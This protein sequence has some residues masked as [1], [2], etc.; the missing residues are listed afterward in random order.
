MTATSRGLSGAGGRIVV[1]VERRPARVAS[2]LAVA[3]VPLAA[4]AMFTGTY[5]LTAQDLLDVV[6]GTAGAPVERVVLL[7]RMPRL[8]AALAVGAALGLSGA[9][10]QSLSRNPLGS[11]DVIGFVTGAAT[12]AITAILLFRAPPAVVSLSAVAGGVLTALLV[13]LLARRPGARDAGYRIVLVGIGMGAL[14]GAANDLLITRGERDDAILAQLWLTGTL[15][16]RGWAEVVP[17]LLAV[18]VLLP[19]LVAAQRALAT[20]ELGDDLAQQLGIRVALLR[21]GTMGAA[22]PRGGSAPATAGPISFVALAAPQ[23]VARLGRGTRPP[24]V[25]S[26]VMGAVLLLAADLLGQHL[27]LQLSAPVGLMTGVLGG[28]YLLWLL[29]RPSRT[30]L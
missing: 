15:N 2:V 21:Y 7:I 23:L 27:P 6:L 10:F 16:A 18:A 5:A 24:I 4:H 22:G 29:A 3:L 12:G 9:V 30:R 28:G 11:P 20:L 1:R 13:A 17:T 14:L 26:A 25:G 19:V 8:V